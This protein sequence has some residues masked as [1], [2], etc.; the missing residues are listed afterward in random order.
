MS[1]VR[2]RLP[3]KSRPSVETSLDRDYDDDMKNIAMVPCVSLVAAALGLSSCDRD[4][5]LAGKNVRHVE[6]KAVSHYGIDLNK[7][8]TPEQVAFVALR[9]IRDDYFATTTKAREAAMDVQFDVAA[10]NVIAS[11]NK[12]S[13]SRD[14]YLHH[15]VSRWTP[16]VDHYASDFEEDFAAATSKFKNRG[17][18]RS[19]GGDTMEVELAME[20]TD[21][22]AGPS[23]HVVMVVYLAQDSGF[24][25][26]LH[27]GFEPKRV[28]AHGPSSGSS[29]PGGT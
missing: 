12:T 9:A 26:V 1:L 5:R 24:W 11:R 16:S 27:F 18:N 22:Q 19:T 6:V 20:L 29:P 28:L 7:E 25:R 2:W 15:V 13:F 23:A 3:N 21:R 14:D 8:A 10:A 4:V 17:M